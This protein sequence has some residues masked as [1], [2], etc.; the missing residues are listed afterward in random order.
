MCRTGRLYNVANWNADGRPLEI[1]H[2]RKTLLEIAVETG[3]QPSG[4]DRQ[5]KASKNSFKRRRVGIRGFIMKAD[6]VQL[7][8]E[9]RSEPMRNVA[10]QFGVSECMDG[11]ALQSASNTGARPGLLDDKDARKLT[12]KKPALPSLENRRRTSRI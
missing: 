12:P 10:K 8:S 4:F 11:E 9:K 6:L 2:A 3:F 5:G 1:P 7:P